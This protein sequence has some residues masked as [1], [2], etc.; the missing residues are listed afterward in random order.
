MTARGAQIA[1]L[2]FVVVFAV[3]V[4]GLNSY[5]THVF[6]GTYTWDAVHRYGYPRRR[7]GRTAPIATT[8][9]FMMAAVCGPWISGLTW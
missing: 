7:R 8:A 9:A 3:V 4:L 5:I 1:V 2:S 6:Y